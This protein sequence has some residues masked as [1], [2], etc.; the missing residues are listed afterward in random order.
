[1]VDPCIGAE[2]P[3]F[4]VTR[5]IRGATYIIEV[6]NSGGKGA[7]LTVDGVAIEGNRVPYAAAGS[8]ANVTAT[9]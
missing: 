1:M 8:T 5:Q 7:K 6:T 9:V 4:T 3:E 2:V